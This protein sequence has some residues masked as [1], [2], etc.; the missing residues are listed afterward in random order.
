M[1]SEE[2]KSL[3]DLIFLNDQFILLSKWDI[4]NALQMNVFYTF[5]YQILPK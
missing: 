5:I 1:I 4:K 3:A 2:Q